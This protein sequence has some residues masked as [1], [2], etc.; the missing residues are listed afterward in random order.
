MVSAGV[1]SALDLLDRSPRN[2]SRW[3]TRLCIAIMSVVWVCDLP[4]AMGQ[5]AQTVATQADELPKVN[6]EGWTSSAVC[7]ECHQAIHAVWQHSLHAMS[8]SNGVFQA[9]Y[10]RSIERY[11]E[12]QARACLSCHAPTVRHGGDFGVKN[13]V[14]AEGVT[15]D[16]CHSVNAV[17]LSDSSDPFRLTVGGS[18]HGPLR[19]AQSP[20][21]EVQ[22]SQLHTRSEFCAPCHE[23]RNAN[24][25]TVLGTYSEWKASPYAKR[26]KQCQDC[27]M[28][29]VEGRVVAL[30]VKRDTP[31][32]VN[33]HNISGSH[34]I[35]RVRG[36]VELKLTGYEW[37]GDRAWVY[38][39]VKNKGSGHCFPTGLPMRRAELVV[40]IRDGA[41]PVDE[42]IIPFQAVMEDKSGRVLQE[43]HRV[44]IEAARVR[45]D[46]R[47]KPGETRKL[48]ISFRDIK[49]S[50][51]T[52][53]AVLSYEYETEALMIEQGQERFEPV[54]MKFL[55]ASVQDTMKPL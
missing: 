5:L 40:T 44:F 47:I 11:G 52:V 54:Q 6:K 43:E 34:D 30:G 35:E 32:S 12:E 3:R 24:G 22:D 27:H 8:W 29:L 28:P 7:G 1:V 20:A 39:S 23:Y 31:T 18:K 9:R 45:S 4:P 19:H 38:V 50:R 53:D 14:T 21:H 37:F 49:A 46:T 41:K 17:D 2:V 26:G 10:R 48:E 51:L 15:C 55:I 25:L 42:R 16:F 33:L 13:A 36:A